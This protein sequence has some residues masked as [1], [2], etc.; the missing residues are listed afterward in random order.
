MLSELTGRP[1]TLL[2]SKLQAY[3]ANE[4]D[5]KDASALLLDCPI[6]VDQSPRLS[7]GTGLVA[8]GHGGAPPPRRSRVERQIRP[9]HD[10]PDGIGEPGARVGAE[11]RSRRRRLCCRG[12]DR[13]TW[14]QLP[15]D[16]RITPVES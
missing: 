11:P 13:G 15:E 9:P 2:R 6:D 4:R 7:A 16:D 10:A 3:E 1:C 8:D 5:L 14:H 12:G